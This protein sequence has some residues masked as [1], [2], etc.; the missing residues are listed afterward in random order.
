MGSQLNDP[1]GPML[2]QEDI[3]GSPK[4]MQLGA[5][6]LLV[7]LATVG[8][9]MSGVIGENVEE[10]GGESESETSV[11]EELSNKQKRLIRKIIEN[12]PIGEKSAIYNDQ[13]KCVD[14]VVLSKGYMDCVKPEELD[15]VPN[16]THVGY[17]FDERRYLAGVSGIP[18]K[19]PNKIL[20]FFQRE[21]K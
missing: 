12:S 19:P 9:R 3:P 11:V 10:G 8:A 14:V 5:L 6:C 7:V 15:L 17:N 21:K 20:S 4:K 1:R 13:K 2:L 16:E 18:K